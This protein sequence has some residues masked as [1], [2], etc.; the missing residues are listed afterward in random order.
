VRAGANQR[1][2]HQQYQHQ[3]CKYSCLGKDA[4]VN[5]V[6][7]AVAIARKEILQRE[8]RAAIADAVQCDAD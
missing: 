6:E 2:G 7:V 8:M 4:Y 3:Q 1:H 5:R